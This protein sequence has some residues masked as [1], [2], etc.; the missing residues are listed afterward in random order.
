[1][2][3]NHLKAAWRNLIK[4]KGFS[5]INITGLAI[6]LATC[7][8]IFLY[9]RDEMS[10]DKYNVKADRI[11]RLNNE[12]LFG[13]NHLDFAE[14]PAAMGGAVVREIPE[15][16]NY[17]R[18]QW[19]GGF[20][21]RKGNEN[22]REGR[23]AFADSSLFDV[24][25]FPVLSGSAAASL[26]E[27]HTLVMTETAAR[28][29]FN[30]SDV[31]GRVLTLNDNE[32]YRISAVIKDIPK[33]SH[34]N[35]DFFLPMREHEDSRTDN[36]LSEDYNTYILLKP[37]ASAAKFE[38]QL[39]PL[40]DRHVGP[41]LQQFANLSLEQLTK[42][43]GFIKASTTALTD[44]HLRSHHS[45]ELE[46]NGNIQIVYIFSGVAIFILL[47]ACANFMNLA[48]ARSANRARE[49][50]VR[51]ALGSLKSTLVRQFLTESFLITGIALVLAMVLARFAVPWFNT[52]SGKTIDGNV[53]FQPYVL[54]AVVLLLIVVGFVAGS[55]P[56]FVLASFN[57]VEVLKGK[58]ATGFRKSSLR[59]GLVV[60]QFV[61]SIMLIVGTIVIY[62]QLDFIQ[63]ADVGYS[64]SQVL[65]IKQTGILGTEARSFRDQVKALPGVE[66]A[67]MS[68]FLPTAPL[69]SSSTYFM[70]PALVANT[71]MNL[72]QWP[73]DEE[74][75]PTLGMKVLQGRNFRRDMPT[76][77]TGV[78]INEAAA[79]FLGTGSPVGKQIW[80]VEDAQTK[81]LKAYNVIGVIK[82]FNFN[83]LRDNIT[84]LGFF[85]RKDDGSVS[86]RVRASAMSATIE[87]ARALWSSF[88]PGKP[89]DYG[90]LDE[91]F[92]HQYDSEQRSGRVFIS[93]AILAVAI[94][95][96]GL[97]GL[98]TFA[99]E[100]RVREIGIRKVLGA[101]VTGIVT[102]ISKDFVKLVLIASLIAFPI[103]GWAMHKWL[104]EFAY[105]TALSW[106]IFP[107]TAGLILLL[108]LATVVGQAVRAA[109]ANP[110]QSLRSE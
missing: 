66:N 60:F 99:A 29:Y 98:V 87:K 39:K 43:G 85:L 88:A 92:S 59:N 30:T 9:I 7:L 4:N 102:L 61:I 33:A 71:A 34:F 5:T 78:V 94:G 72:Q 40:M 105:R 23:V 101:D 97:F 8:L 54:A 35:F 93:F 108:A 49:V 63:K 62:K 65:T 31:A 103:A 81:K 83:S 74:Y 95:C 17:T 107:L 80:E 86:A 28:R 1:M 70:S 15:A 37:N 50:G 38:A 3:K 6:G 47:I 45:A 96:L 82:N 32:S 21:V 2:F 25:T 56:S 106:W 55:Y 51:K 18:I 109:L 22:V 53:L 44:I 20:T 16:E 14:V 48:T 89:F 110:V 27:P 84:P 46:T 67:T 52:L 90:F 91:D 57:P 19:R 41:Q 73:V 100:Q 69:R 26:R 64:R 24:F 75:I 76:D 12:I 104:Q 68:S 10:F 42:N 13:D 11:L 36:W 79:K 58:L 77:S